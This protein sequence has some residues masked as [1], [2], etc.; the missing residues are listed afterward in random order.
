MNITG[1]W[2]NVHIRT[3]HQYK[4]LLYISQPFDAHCYHRVQL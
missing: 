2:Q 1:T 4:D 3:K